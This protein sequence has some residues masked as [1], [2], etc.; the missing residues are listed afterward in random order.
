MTHL[1]R[2][3]TE[4]AISYGM[5]T[6]LLT[7]MLISTASAGTVA[8]NFTSTTQKNQY[9]TPKPAEVKSTNPSEAPTADNSQPIAQYEPDHD[10]LKT[11]ESTLAEIKVSE[12]PQNQPDTKKTITQ[13]T[14]KDG[15]DVDIPAVPINVAQLN[16]T[17]GETQIL[18]LDNAVIA[19]KM[20]VIQQ[21]AKETPLKQPA[22]VAKKTV[23]ANKAPTAESPKVLEAE[24]EKTTN[25]QQTGIEAP[26]QVASRDTNTVITDASVV[27]VPSPTQK[28]DVPT[29]DLQNLSPKPV[30]KGS[31]QEVP[32]SQALNGEQKLSPELTSGSTTE[33]TPVSMEKTSQDTSIDVP[34][35][36]TNGLIDPKTT[37]SNTANDQ[38]TP[39]SNTGNDQSTPNSKPE[40]FEIS[41]KTQPQQEN[42]SDGPSTKDMTSVQVQATAVQPQKGSD[43]LSDQAQN[44]GVE[45]S[46]QLITDNDIQP[47]LTQQSPMLAPSAKTAPNTNF[48][49]TISQQIQQSVQT[50]IKSSNQ[51]IV[52]RLNP[53]ELGN[54]AIK[55]QEQGGD[56]TGVLQVDRLQTKLQIEQALPEIVQ[57]LQDS[58]I[59]IKKV[60]VVLANQQEQYSAKDQSAAQ[61][62]NSFAGN[63]NTSDQQSNTNNPAY[64]EWIPSNETYGGYTEHQ[65]QLT[66]TTINMLV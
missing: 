28:S 6:G 5:N 29:A 54:V 9:S 48:D 65:Q 58:G 24:T 4:V 38:N 41:A 18:Q 42:I 32:A 51:Q 14:D 23:I 37:D 40:L 26:P 59:Q 49:A 21:N 43:L 39:N 52:I 46:E 11:F 35:G 62:Q 36:Q 3:G 19:E 30:A 45:I 1:G 16:I 53:P 33:K 12:N 7:N 50:T 27:A 63:Q 61:G 20:P 64:N 44:S 55:F 66:E 8:S 25:N 57:N 17:K 10:P 34:K 31:V 22:V 2:A 60:E 47:S 13:S 15:S 56:I